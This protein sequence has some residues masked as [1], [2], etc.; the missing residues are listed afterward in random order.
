VRLLDP[1]LL[2][3]RFPPDLL[4]RSLAI[5]FDVD[6]LPPSRHTGNYSVPQTFGSPCLAAANPYDQWPSNVVS[7]PSAVTVNSV[8]SSPGTPAYVHT[9][10]PIADG[11]VM[12]SSTSAPSI[13][14]AK[15]EYQELDAG[16]DPKSACKALFF[17]SLPGWLA[18]CADMTPRLRTGKQSLSQP[19][20]ALLFT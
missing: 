7:V 15:S 2:A 5:V 17:P 19:R 1:P 13:A 4:T 8:E 18:P 20:A 10:V 9:S 3:C 16:M 11:A 6:G 12:P 14:S